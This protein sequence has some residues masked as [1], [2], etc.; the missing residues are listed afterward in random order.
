MDASS[1]FIGGSYKS[2]SPLA[3][4]EELY[5][6]YKES[7]QVPGAS[8]KDGLY[9]TPGVQTI[10]EVAYGN[11]RAHIE[12]LTREFAVI[13]PSFVEIYQNGTSTVR[14]TVA[15]DANPATLSSS[16]D[17]SRE[18]F[19]TS[20]GNGYIFNLDTNAFS[21]IAVLAGKATMGAYLDGYFLALDSSLSAVYSSVLGDGTT[22]DPNTY[23]TQ[24][25]AMADRWVSMKVVGR[26]IYLLGERTSEIWYDAG[27]TPFPFGFYTGAP[28][29]QYGCLAPFSPAVIGDSLLWVAL[30]SSGR[31]CIVKA[32]LQAQQASTYPIDVALEKYPDATLAIGD[33]YSD[34]GH[35]FYRV[36]FDESNVSW[37]LDVEGGE[38]HKDGEW[39]RTTGQ[40]ESWRPRYYVNVFGQ[41]RMLDGRGR[42]VFQMSGD[43]ST[44]ANGDPI[45]RLRQTP[46]FTS[47]NDLIFYSSLEL[48]IETGLKSLESDPPHAEFTWTMAEATTL[49]ASDSYSPSGSITSYSWYVNG[50]LLV[51]TTSPSYYWGMGAVEGD[52]ILL[53]VHSPSG[54]ASATATVP[55]ATFSGTST[56]VSATGVDREPQVMLSLSNDAG[57]T[58]ITEQWRGAGKLGEYQ[59]RV[60]WQ[61]LGAARRRVFRVV[62]ADEYPWRLVGADLRISQDVPQGEKDRG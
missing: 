4:C 62:C 38:W 32:S 39:N 57:R 27:L 58:W 29:I 26:L 17:L 8:A 13:G 6:W 15:L 54:T 53:V 14:G 22:W 52:V 59:R 44:Q 34:R 2:Q 43:Y 12:T 1:L 5:N 37:A 18:V 60:R 51:T 48:F 9:P 46:A 55:P 25:S 61:G 19:I 35:T 31:R 24:R 45:R 42:S 36:S 11:G 28:V 30:S 10:A 33:A 50:T 20:G 49:D 56:P 16:G 23:W 47:G 40:W 41:H 21:A 7:M 3:D